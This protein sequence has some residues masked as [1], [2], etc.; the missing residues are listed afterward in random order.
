MNAV[1]GGTFD[2]IHDGHLHLIRSL[3]KKFDFEKFFIVPAGQNPLK[4]QRPLANAQQ[5]LEMVQLAV[6]SLGPRMEVLD[7]E[8]KAPPP[9]YTVDTLERLHQSGVG[10]LT[11]IMG[12]DV[13]RGFDGWKDP[14]RIRELATLLIVTRTGQ[15]DPAQRIAT[16]ELDALPYSA[17]ELRNQ[18]YNFWKTNG[19]TPR[20]SGL[21]DSVWAFIKEKE[22]YTELPT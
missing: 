16:F 14:D 20:P 5:R 22:L 10:P 21:P 9:S 8:V 17:T 19:L 2:P 15:A 6:E 1:L 4:S 11:L 7:W 13:Y 18:L 12:D 3:I